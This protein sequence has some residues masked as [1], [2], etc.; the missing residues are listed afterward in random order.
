MNEVIKKKRAVLSLPGVML[1]V[2]GECP[3]ESAEDT[4]N[5]PSR[6]DMFMYGITLR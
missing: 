3:Q 1:G 6:F 2:Y 4:A 5:D